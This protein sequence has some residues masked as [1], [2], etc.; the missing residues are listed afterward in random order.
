MQF[1]NSAC[2]PFGFRNKYALQLGMVRVWP[3]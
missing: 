2:M 3:E 1:Q